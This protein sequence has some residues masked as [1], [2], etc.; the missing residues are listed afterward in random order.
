MTRLDA[1]PIVTSRLVLVP[2]DDD[3]AEHILAGDLSALDHTEGWPHADTFDALPLGAR[4]AA[5]WLVRLDGIVIG[6]CGTTGPVENSTVEIGFGLAA[7]RRGQGYGRELVAALTA[8]LLAQGGIS[9]VRA[10]T[11]AGNVASRRVLERSGF[12]L[13]RKADGVLSYAH[14]NDENVG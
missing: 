10:T 14:G 8:W 7:E 12:V 9:R 3:G 1:A 13:D 6:D 4:G 11:D 2:L 5:L